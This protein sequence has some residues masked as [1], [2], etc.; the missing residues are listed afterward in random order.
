[1][2]WFFRQ[3]GVLEI[4]YFKMSPDQFTSSE[5]SV[6]TGSGGDGTTKRCNSRDAVAYVRVQHAAD[7]AV[8]QNRVE[9]RKRLHCG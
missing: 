8:L 5:S 9:D 4:I 3:N 6:M 1:M 2:R 7:L